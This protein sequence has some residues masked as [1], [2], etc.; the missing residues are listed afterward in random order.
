MKIVNS[1]DEDGVQKEKDRNVCFA[2]RRCLATDAPECHAS[3]VTGVLF[4]HL[5]RGR[6]VAP[7]GQFGHSVAPRT[8]SLGTNFQRAQDSSGLQK[9]GFVHH[10]PINQ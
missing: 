6:D 2:V 3:R 1:M 7:H 4:E 5:M 9:D 8:K 10:L